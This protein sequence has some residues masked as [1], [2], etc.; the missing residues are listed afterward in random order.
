M[1]RPRTLLVTG[2][3]ENQWADEL[4][5]LEYVEEQGLKGPSMR[6]CYLCKREEGENSLKIYEDN[7]EEISLAPI[8]LHSCEI[9]LGGGITFSYLLCMECTLLLDAMEM[10]EPEPDE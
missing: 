2:L 10:M 6:K 9:T 4:R 1:I 7:V 8:E 3:T 5:M